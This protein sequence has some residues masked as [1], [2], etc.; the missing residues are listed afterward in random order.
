MLRPPARGTVS[1]GTTMAVCVGQGGVAGVIS[2]VTGRSEDGMESV[3]W[4]L[5]NPHGE[6]STGG[7]QIIVCPSWLRPRECGPPV[8][9]GMISAKEKSSEIYLYR[10]WLSGRR[11]Q[12][13]R[14]FQVFYDAFL[15]F[16]HRV[17]TARRAI[18]LRRSGVNFSARALPPSFPPAVPILTKYANT[19]G[20]SFC[21]FISNGT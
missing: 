12:A 8:G 18:S 7:S 19:F 11:V 14:A 10:A 17:S 1:P 9:H 3:V 20:G 15:C 4:S 6:L 13:I 16:A 5:S 21:F 2:N